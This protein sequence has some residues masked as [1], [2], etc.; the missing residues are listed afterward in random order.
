MHLFLVELYCT[1]KIFFES[2]V[3]RKKC[4][5]F[6]Y[7]AFQAFK[8]IVKVVIF[9]MIVLPVS[10]NDFSAFEFLTQNCSICFYYYH[11]FQKALQREDNTST[12]LLLCGR[13]VASV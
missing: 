9:H 2:L 6:F 11:F 12:L 3:I 10:D 4:F 13:V 5:S 7:K 8:V 1:Y